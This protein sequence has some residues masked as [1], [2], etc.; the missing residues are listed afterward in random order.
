MSTRP[1]FVQSSSYRL[2]LQHE[3][4]SRF[5]YR[6]QLAK[7]VSPQ[8]KPTNPQQPKPGRPTK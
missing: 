3:K 6:I 4:S 7:P 2:G 8:P 5:P 1:Q